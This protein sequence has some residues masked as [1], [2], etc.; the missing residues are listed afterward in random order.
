M[1]KYKVI[2]GDEEQQIW[3]QVKQDLDNINYPFVYGANIQH[4]EKTVF[5]SIEVDLGG[6]FESG[7][8]TTSLTAPVPVQFTALSSRLDTDKEFRFVLHDEDF[9]DKVGKFFGMEDVH[10]GYEEFDK[11]LIVKTNDIERV[12]KIFAD[13]ETRKLFISLGSFNLHI[14]HYEQDEPHSA[15]EL[16]IDRDITN[17]EDLKHVYNAFLKVLESFEVSRNSF[18]H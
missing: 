4:Q 5:L 13:P 15:L 16:T 3:D 11:K 1:E 14:A 10:T 9:I 2:R 17:V 7:F 6:G 8:Q 12:K 18:S